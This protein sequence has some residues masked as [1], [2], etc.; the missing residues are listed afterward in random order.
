MLFKIV[1]KYIKW[2]KSKKV[3]HFI[4]EDNR[5]DAIKRYEKRKFCKWD[6]VELS[7]KEKWEFVEYK[8]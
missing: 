4:Y 3:A 8:I 6:I 2:K 7:V 1:A 5:S